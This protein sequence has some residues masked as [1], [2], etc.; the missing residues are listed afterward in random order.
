[1]NAKSQEKQGKI[2]IGRMLFLRRTE[3]SY[4]SRRR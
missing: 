2:Y 3:S 4:K 1:M